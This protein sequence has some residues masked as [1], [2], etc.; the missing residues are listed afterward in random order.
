MIV[1]RGRNFGCCMGIGLLW[2]IVNYKYFYFVYF[3]FGCCY[4]GR[5]NIVYNVYN[6][7]LKGIF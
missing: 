5:V 3:G 1:R 4:Y 6:I 7:E 2:F